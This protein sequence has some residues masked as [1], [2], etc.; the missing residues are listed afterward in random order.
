MQILL[1]GVNHRTAP[2]EVRERMAFTSDQAVAAS[3]G[4]REEG[5]FEEAVVLSTCNRSEIYGA[6]PAGAQASRALRE[7]FLRFHHLPPALPDGC[8]YQNS[9]VETAR[10]LFRVAAGLDSMLLGEAEIL[11]QVRQ[12]Y[13]LALENQVTG[14]ILNRLFQGALEVGKRVR[15]Q[16]DIGARPMSVAFAGV[17]LAERVFGNL[18]GHN[19]LVL[20][21]GAMAEQAVGHLRNRG[22]ERILV[23]NRSSDHARQLARRFAGEAVEW[24]RLAEVLDLPDVIISSVSAAAP[25]LTRPMM[26]RAMAARNNRE[27]FLID[28][29]VPR[30]VAPEIADLYNLY[31]YDSEDLSEIVE[32]NRRARRDE[33]P[34][35][36][37]IITEHVSKFRAWLTRTQLASLINRLRRM[38]ARDREGFLHDRLA[39]MTHLSP[40]D[41]Q[42]LADFARQLLDRDAFDPLSGDD[43]GP[44]RR[45]RDLEAVRQLLG[46][47]EEKP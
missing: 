22:M 29:G 15:A 24:S 7:F 44:A 41:C 4:L 26:E 17:K 3:R 35:A 39:R 30:N 16:T 31:L 27:V 38:E 13:K 1:I 47:A 33:I 36:E 43:A 37:A 32:Q 21:A 42:R 12:A 8:L 9:D 34:R 6:A 45:L 23:A 11:G 5:L 10:H 25:V 28:L 2:L 19:A 14:P 18:R 46:P 40:E 20:G